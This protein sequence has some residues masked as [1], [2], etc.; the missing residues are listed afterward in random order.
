MR[1][2]SVRP[3]AAQHLDVAVGDQQDQRAAVGCGG[4]RVDALRAAGLD[5]RV[6]GQERRE[7][8]RDADR[9]HAGAAA[10]V[11]DR[12]GLVQIQVAHVRADV[13]G[14]G[15]ADL[16]IHVGAVHVHLAAVVVD[17]AR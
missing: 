13:A 16:R 14:A 15:Q 5:H 11:R 3:V 10:A 7:M 1:V 12:E 6:P 9:A 2:A 17:D 8:C 4:Y